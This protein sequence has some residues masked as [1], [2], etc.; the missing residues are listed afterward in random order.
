MSRMKL[1]RPSLAWSWLT[2]V[3]PRPE[4]PSITKVETPIVL[5]W[6]VQASMVGLTP[7]EPCISTTAGSL[8]MPWAMRS[9][10]AIVTG[11]PLAS[12]VRNCWSERVRE[13]MAWISTRAATSLGIAC[14]LVSMQVN[15]TPV[16]KIAAAVATRQSVSIG[17]PHNLL[18]AGTAARAPTTGQTC[19]RSSPWQ[20]SIL[21]NVGRFVRRVCG[22]PTASFP[23]LPRWVNANPLPYFSP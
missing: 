3:R 21:A 9:S 17:C 2:D 5:R 1:S 6:R 12:P 16:Q 15:S 8:P 11:V 13:G 4:N 7:P 23:I 14:A 18:L 20:G 10:P 22:Y 19:A